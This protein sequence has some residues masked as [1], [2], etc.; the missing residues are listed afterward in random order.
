M[1]LRTLAIV[2]VT[3]LAWGGGFVAFVSSMPTGSPCPICYTDAI[4]VLTGGNSRLSEGLELLH[5]GLASTLYISGV[6]PGTSL[7]TVIKKSGYKGP[8][9]PS[10]IVM[11]YEARST[12]E[13]SQK[14]MAWISQ[15][16]IHTIRLVT[17]NYHMRRALLEFK[18]RIGDKVKIL[19]HAVTPSDSTQNA[20]Y[21][22]HKVLSLY[23]NEYHKYLG[24]LAR[25]IIREIY[26]RLHP[27]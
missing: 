24:A 27:S 17:A 8:L 21:K 4:V 5:K 26:I 14:V 2:I 16:P 23:L 3:V 7:Q 11:D 20:W 1:L 22:D 15:H 19:V 9:D 13:N 18:Q 12:L 6:H 10:K 25:S